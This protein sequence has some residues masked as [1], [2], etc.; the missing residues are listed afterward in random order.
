[1]PHK[2]QMWS[3][4]LVEPFILRFVPRDRLI[5]AQSIRRVSHG[6]VFGDFAVAHEAS[7]PPWQCPVEY[8]HF[9][10]ICFTHLDLI[11]RGEFINLAFP[12]NRSPANS[13][14]RQRRVLPVEIVGV[15]SLVAVAVGG[16]KLHDASERRHDAGQGIHRGRWRGGENL[17]VPCYN[18]A[19]DQFTISYWRFMGGKGGKCHH[20]MHP[21]RNVYCMRNLRS[22]I[23]TRVLRKPS[24][25]I[26]GT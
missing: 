19:C 3:R 26:A 10:Q 24:G 8:W 5:V 4:P 18:L 25:C 20:P 7:A 13:A 23:T 16:R 12:P 22:T 14:D 11:E 15:A 6:R 9:S 17:R 1:M 21:V 2:I